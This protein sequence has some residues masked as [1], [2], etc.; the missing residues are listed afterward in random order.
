MKSARHQLVLLGLLCQGLVWDNYWLVLVNA[1]LWVSC[2]NFR[3]RTVRLPPMVEVA[4]MFGGM[5]AGY[6]LDL[7]AGQSVHFSVGHG[8]T[9]LQCLR[10]RRPLDRR[11]QIFSILMALLQF[12]VACTVVLDYRFV[13]IL[14]GAMVIV[15]RTLMELES[16]SFLLATERI[17]QPQLPAPAGVG[18][19]ALATV[20]GVAILFFLTFPRGFLAMAL[21][22]APPRGQDGGSLLDSVMDPARSAAAQS[23]RVLLQVDADR[24]GYLRCY[25]LT[26]FDGNQWSRDA[27]SAWRPIDYAPQA[28]KENWPVRRV[29]AKN[30]L[31]LGRVLP[32]DG[33]VAQL[34]GRFFRRAFQSAHGIVECEAMW[35]TANNLYEYRI[36]PHP[37]LEGLLST[38]REQLTRH[39]PASARLNAWLDQVLAGETDPLQQARRLEKYLQTRFTYRLGAP[40]L[41]R[42][43][44]LED[45][46][47]NQREGHCERFASALALLL[48]VKDTPTRVVIGYLPSRRNWISGWYDIRFKDAHAWIEAWF[49]EHGWVQLD[50]TPRASLPPSGLALSDAMETIDS[51]WYAN[52]VNFDTSTQNQLLAISRQTISA[53]PEWLLDHGAWVAPLLLLPLAIMLGRRFRRPHHER[54]TDRAERRRE[55]Q[56]AEHDYTRLLGLL[57]RQ[58]MTR[59]PQLTPNEFLSQLRQHSLPTLADVEFITGVFCETRYG[60]QRLTPTRQAEV[61]RALR[62]VESDPVLKAGFA[63]SPN[64]LLRP[65]GS[66]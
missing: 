38:R 6:F 37:P 16:N 26:D 21:P 18:R 1:A 35:N 32:T 42:L 60:Q 58:G 2:L 20:A 23:S 24:L 25:A 10:L 63:R 53:T 48:R 43:N 7:T 29:R 65:P 5:L 49:P 36:H 39:P 9:I 28:Q 11:E 22:I 56:L 50:A 57:A 17:P 55:V 31:W 52:V 27:H 30:A 51:A 44:S 33:R 19:W 34:S 40:E 59:R 8:V 12:G 54:D 14:L 61:E 66:P 62:R 41:D 13:L 3:R 4:A 46:L 45:F 47:F 15:P 64:R